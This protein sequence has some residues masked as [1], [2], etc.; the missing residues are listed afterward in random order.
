MFDLPG[1]I[2]R[3]HKEFWTKESAA[4]FF[5][6]ILLFSLA[7]IIQHFAYNY[8]D[9]GV[10]GTH[11]GDLL[12]D[13]LPSVNLDWFVVQGALLST[14]LTLC[15]FVIKPNYLLFS[16]KAMALFV[17]TRSFFISLTHLGTSPNEVS[18]NT[19]SIGFGIY[20]FLYN[21]KNDFFFSGHTGTAV[22]FALIL[23]KEKFWRILFLAIS[24]IF[25]ASMLLSHRHYSIDIFAAPFITYGIFV[26]T[27]NL[28]FYDY[29]LI[30][31]K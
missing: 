12:L 23:W 13:N 30:K 24:L 19:H 17:I 4:G 21:G 15:L 22:M 28:F 31:T 1:K 29:G 25:G 20:D 11:V 5:N 16:V 27:K 6:G 10:S 7:L 26:I 8:I 14:F 3:R 18:I 9:N 2:Y